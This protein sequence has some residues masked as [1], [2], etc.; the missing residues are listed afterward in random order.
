MLF[1]STHVHNEDFLNSCSFYFSFC[2]NFTT[3]FLYFDVYLYL[4][5]NEQLHIF[6]SLKIVG[7]ISFI[8]YSLYKFII[9]LWTICL[10]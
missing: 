6:Y 4:F 9:L 3:I 7:S 5:F 2:H 8:C 10:L 1:L